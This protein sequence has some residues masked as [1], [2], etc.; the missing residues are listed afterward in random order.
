MRHSLVQARHV[1]RHDVCICVCAIRVFTDLILAV[2]VAN[3]TSV[4]PED[5]TILNS[6]RFS[7]P[8]PVLST[9]LPEQLR[10]GGSRTVITLTGLNFGAD[11]TKI[12]VT[13]GAS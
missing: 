9:V 7:Y 4:P 13:V 5:P 8:P 6:L 3:Q 2:R 1:H 11:Q 10:T 12:R